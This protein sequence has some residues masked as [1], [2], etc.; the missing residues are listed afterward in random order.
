MFGKTVD[1]DLIKFLKPIILFSP[2]FKR[3]R[4][5]TKDIAVTTNSGLKYKVSSVGHLCPNKSVEYSENTEGNI[6]NI[7][8]TIHGNQKLANEQM[9]SLNKKYSNPDMDIYRSRK[10]V[11]EEYKLD[12]PACLSGNALKSVIKSI[13][14]YLHY[15]GITAINFSAKY[16]SLYTDQNNVIHLNKIDIIKHR[17]ENIVMHCLVIFTVPNTEL[18]IGYVEI[19][20]VYRTAFILSDDYEGDN[21]RHI[22]AI[23]LSDRTCDLSSQLDINFDAIYNNLNDFTTNDLFCREEQ[24]NIIRHLQF[25][26]MI[27]KAIH[28][29][30][31]ESGIKKG[32]YLTEKEAPHFVQTVIEKMVKEWDSTIIRTECYSKDVQK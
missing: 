32:G 26:G 3:D 17:P 2:V 31:I 12:I 22:H 29:S 1:A 4:G 7:R 25:N 19:F 16:D 23:D 30:F 13:L 5:S 9:K 20:S 15:C 18:L 27:N 8:I 10:V 24:I 11:N 28:Q 14:V 21:V 6:K